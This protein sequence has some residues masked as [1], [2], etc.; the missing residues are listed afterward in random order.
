MLTPPEILHRRFRRRLLGYSVREVHEFLHAVSETV[1]T[2]LEENRL[3]REERERLLERLRTYEALEQHLRDALVVAE[4]VA[5]EVKQAARQ[6]AERI[7]AQARQDAE[8]LR[9]EAEREVQRALAEA[10]RVRQLRRRMEAELRH[11]LQTYL[12]LL[13]Q[14]PLAAP[15]ADEPAP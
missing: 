5:E 14:S 4:R 8:R 3:L 10:E 13:E 6:D 12:D 15:A 11:L 2:L 1:R 9:A 7:I